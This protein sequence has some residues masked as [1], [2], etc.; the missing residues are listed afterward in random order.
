M[1]LLA[2]LPSVYTQCANG[3]ASLGRK[4]TVVTKSG[5]LPFLAC[6][7]G[8]C[9]PGYICDGTD[10]CCEFAT[11][12]CE[13]TTVIW[14]FQVLVERC[15]HRFQVRQAPEGPADVRTHM[16][17]CAHDSPVSAPCSHSVYA[18]ELIVRKHAEPAAYRP[19]G[20]DR[21]GTLNEYQSCP[22]LLLNGKLPDMNAA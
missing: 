2:M 1:F 18:F 7:G 5:A 20:D 14:P 10:N 6:V 9:P 12:T 17:N 22:L 15:H 4:L 11:P 16:D 19:S 3:V 8:I 13:P 21:E